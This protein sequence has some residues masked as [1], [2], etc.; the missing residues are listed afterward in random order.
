MLRRVVR[1]VMIVVLVAAGAA[2]VIAHHSF[3]AQYDRAKPHTISGTV[4]KMEWQNPHIYFYVNV[5]DANGTEA[6]WA[7]EGQAPNGLY[8]QGWRR[9][10]LKAGD[11][12]TVDGWLARDGSKLLNMGTVKM[13]DGR[14]I[15]RGGQ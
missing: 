8:R 5:K 2:P 9:D 3:A 6:E 1:T 7:V 4:T 11:I 14:Q 10:T 13:A 12:V 15:F